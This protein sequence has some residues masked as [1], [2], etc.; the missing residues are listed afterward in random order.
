MSVTSDSGYILEVDLAF[1]KA[2]TTLIRTFHFVRR[3]T[4]FPENGAISFS[5]C[6]D[7]ERYVMHYRNLQQCIRHGLHVKKI[8]Q[9]LRFAQFS[10]LRGYIELNTRFRTTANNEFE[11]NLYK[12]INNAIFGKIME[13]VRDYVDSRRVGTKNTARRR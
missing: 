9:I 1:R 11:K 13:N 4:S 10:W 5:P 2:F 8:H 7:K 3:T 6:S 12:L